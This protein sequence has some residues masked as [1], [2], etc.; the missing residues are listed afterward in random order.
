M[1]LELFAGLSA[2]Q[3]EERKAILKGSADGLNVIRDHLTEKLAQLQKSRLGKQ[4]Y[5]SPSWALL[6]ADKVGEVRALIEVIDLLTLD[7]E[8]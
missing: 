4:D 8:N 3:K 5:G 1:K 6:Q 7:R 2:E